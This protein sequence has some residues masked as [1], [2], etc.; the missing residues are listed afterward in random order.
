MRKS[1]PM[2]M[3]CFAELVSAQATGPRLTLQDA[4][5]MALK[6]HP[7][8]LASQANYLRANE[9]VTET[10]SAYYPALPVTLQAPRPM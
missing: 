3:A 2:L 4:E 10:R 8:V 9:I 6:N 7:Q 1:I 5:A